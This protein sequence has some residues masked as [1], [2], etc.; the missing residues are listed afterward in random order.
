MTDSPDLSAALDLANWHGADELQAAVRRLEEE[1]AAAIAEE[2]AD[3]ETL[4]RELLT[5]LDEVEPAARAS[6]A[7]VYRVT[8]RQLARA[9]RSLLDGGAAS[10]GTESAAHESPRMGVAQVGVCLA[11]YDGRQAGGGWGTRLYRRNQAVAGDAMERALQLLE[12]QAARQ[13]RERLR[14]DGGADDD[15]GPAELARRGIAAYAE[16]AILLDEATAPWRFGR[17]PFAPYELL[18]GSGN[19]EILRRGLAVLRRYV[20]EGVRLA[21]VANPGRERVLELIGSGLRPGEFALVQTDRHRCHQIVE[22]GNLRG[23]HRAYAEAFVREIAPRV[24]CGVCRVTRAAPPQPFW[25]HAD[26]A[27]PAAIALMADAMHRPYA[28]APL[29]PDLARAQARAAFAADGLNASVTAARVQ[30][31]RP[32]G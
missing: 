26:H 4:R 12:S 16:R 31:D 19:M 3:G 22:E 15:R 10:V 13:V 5:R 18:T 32:F 7:G 28:N 2:A 20:E 1:M 17:G 25:C 21:F 11:Q 29:L 6:G 27:V 30:R 23:E 14:P 24:I 9:Q 8:P